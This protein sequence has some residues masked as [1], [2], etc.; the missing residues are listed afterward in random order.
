MLARLSGGDRSYLYRL[1]I[2]SVRNGVL[3][4]S[5]DMIKCYY[6]LVFQHCQHLDEAVHLAHLLTTRD[7]VCHF[8]ARRLSAW[9]DNGSISVYLLIELY[10]KFDPKGCQKYLP[11]EGRPPQIRLKADKLWS[12]D[13]L[14][15]ID[16]DFQS[17]PALK[18]FKRPWLPLHGEVV[19]T[20]RGRREVYDV[21]TDSALLEHMAICDPFSDGL[22]IQLRANLPY[23]LYED[24]Y[25]GDDVI[26]EKEEGD[27]DDDEETEM[28]RRTPT[29]IS[30]LQTR[31]KVLRAAAVFSNHVGSL[32]PELHSFILEDVLPTW[33]GSDEAGLTLCQDL[34]CSLT[35]SRDFHSQ[36]LRFLE[37]FLR[38]GSPRIQYRILATLI[39]K[40]IRTW[41]NTPEAIDLIRWASTEMKRAFLGND[42][43]EMLRVAVIDLYD[44]V[45]FTTSLL[46]NPVIVY[47]LLLS[48]TAV[49]IDHLCSLLMKFREP[50]LTEKA[51]FRG[52]SASRIALFNSFVW[53]IVSACWRNSIAPHNNSCLFNK[54]PALVMAGIGEDLQSA[55][56][57]T[58]SATFVGYYIAG[59]RNR[60]RYVDHLCDR[61]LTGIH[62][63]LVTFSSALADRN[64]RR[65]RL[66]SGNPRQRFLSTRD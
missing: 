57:I 55:L 4:E 65:K 7:V 24:W 26:I 43:H 32:L 12:A 66:K 6:P 18:K 13:L 51:L 15:Y 64:Q 34:L 31:A 56:S 17:E 62:S 20:W 2:L 1:L 22:A 52:G 8:R 50:L 5:I 10:V 58:H 41:G 63:F 59:A 48:R 49:S 19:A 40:W 3:I 45:R 38:F 39:P 37:P 30:L 23:L 44:A 46:P 16:N 33:D 9:Y 14:R 36:V 27:S 28:R 11:R 47:T 25:V 42:A 61:G 35:P 21:L 60:P 29:D 54:I 53:D